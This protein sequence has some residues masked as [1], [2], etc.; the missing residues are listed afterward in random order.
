MESNFDITAWDDGND[1]L[2]QLRR[3]AILYHSRGRIEEAQEIHQL[4]L[5]ISNTRFERESKRS[6]EA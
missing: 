3:L 6:E 2:V 1:T 4:I 5:Q